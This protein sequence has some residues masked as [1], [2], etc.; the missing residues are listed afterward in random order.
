MKHMHHN[1]NGRHTGHSRNPLGR[2]KARL[3][4]SSG[5]EGAHPSHAA[6]NKAHGTPQGFGPP[7][8]YQD[9]DPPQSICDDSDD[10]CNDCMTS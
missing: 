3:I 10:H 9:Q 8:G 1:A 2:G 6:M 7:E 4:P 5:S